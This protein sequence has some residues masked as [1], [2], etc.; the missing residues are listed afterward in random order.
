MG[1]LECQHG[2]GGREREGYREK[3]GGKERGRWSVGK[4]ARIR[5][6]TRT[7]AT[8]GAGEVEG[9]LRGGES[10]WRERE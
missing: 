10:E 4:P 1:T 7:G 8:G 9:G 3:E 5:H 2:G 6:G